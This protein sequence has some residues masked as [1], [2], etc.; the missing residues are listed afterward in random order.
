[1]FDPKSRIMTFSLK[2]KM[3]LCRNIMEMYQLVKGVQETKKWW[4]GRKLMRSQLIE[5][6]IYLCFDSDLYDIVGATLRTDNASAVVPFLFLIHPALNTH[7]L[8]ICENTVR[9][10]EFNF[11]TIFNIS[12]S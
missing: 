9:V 5:E 2:A 12:E 8:N 1:M 7:L 4:R 6:R 11:Y 10:H 3:V